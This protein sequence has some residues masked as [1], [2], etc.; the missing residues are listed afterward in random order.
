MEWSFRVRISDVAAKYLV[1]MDRPADSFPYVRIDFDG[2]IVQTEICKNPGDPTWSHRAGFEYRLLEEDVQAAIASLCA[3]TATLTVFFTDGHRHVPAGRT[4]VDLFSIASG[5]AVFQLPLYAAESL[6]NGPPTSGTATSGMLHFTVQME[7]VTTVALRP[8][9][10]VVATLP[11][12]NTT[13]RISASLLLSG[14]GGTGPSAEVD[15]A[16]AAGTANPSW[17]NQPTDL[18]VVLTRSTLRGLLDNVLRLHFREM[19]RGTLIGIVD[20]PMRDIVASHANHTSQFKKNLYADPSYH[21]PFTALVTGTIDIVDIPTFAQLSS[22]L[23]TKAG[24]HGKPLLPTSTLPPRYT[25][26]SQVLPDVERGGPI[27]SPM[28]P[29]G[30]MVTNST[31]A[32]RL[33]SQYGV[34]AR[35]GSASM[36]YSSPMKRVLGDDAGPT[37]YAPPAARRTQSPPRIPVASQPTPP[38]APSLVAPGPPLSIRQVPAN[39]ASATAALMRDKSPLRGVGNALMAQH[40]EA[41]AHIDLQQ[42]RIDSMAVELRDRTATEQRNSD[43]RLDAL[44]LEERVVTERFNVCNAQ[45]R[46]LQ[47]LLDSTNEQAASD[48]RRLEAE[49]TTLTNEWEELSDVEARLSALLESIQHHAEDDARQI[50]E[51]RRQARIA[52]DRLDHDTTALVGVESRMIRHSTTATA[53]AYHHTS[54]GFAGGGGGLSSAANDAASRI[55][56][57]ATVGNNGSGVSMLS[58]S[59]GSS[60]QPYSIANLLDAI[61]AGNDAAFDRMIGASPTLLYADYTLLLKAC[62]QPIPRPGIVRTILRHRAELVHVVEPSTGNTPLHMACAA[63]RP[64]TEVVELLLAHGASSTAFN[65]EGLSPFH[66]AVL[67]SNDTTNSVRRMLLFKGH[68]ASVEQRTAKGE[69]PAHLIAVHDRHLT[70]ARFLAEHGANFQQVAPVQSGRDILQLT[71]LQKARLHGA[72]ATAVTAFLEANTS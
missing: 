39:A 55:L 20:I 36:G 10:V 2:K 34:N 43:A 67:N 50:E 28:H 71:P 12:A 33:L 26:H 51:A 60:Q 48:F 46:E 57:D 22:G 49:R 62:N 11:S 44:T 47:T 70:A 65:G 27:A 58:S 61:G 21:T 30:G 14:E 72:S 9:S 37:N 52:R 32:E 29:P 38:P 25:R 8:Q 68:G 64:C 66:V 59:V 4:A 69:A 5:A 13:T 54:G 6:T 56:A 17:G 31:A 63:Q 45:V 3:R 53:L 40:D 1:C 42:R 16:L 35:D 24:I 18:P 41:A 23:H 7:Q 19:P 15:G